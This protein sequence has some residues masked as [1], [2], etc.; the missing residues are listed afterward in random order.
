MKRYLIVAMVTILVLG[1]NIPLSAVATCQYE[2]NLNATIEISGPPLLEI[3]G[4]TGVSLVTQPS[5][6][7]LL[8]TFQPGTTITLRLHVFYLDGTPVDLNPLTASFAFYSDQAQSSLLTV[9]DAPVVPEPGAGPGYYLYNFTIPKDWSTGGVSV[10]AL[11]Q[12]LHDAGGNSNL[13]D[14]A[15]ANMTL[16][17]VA[18]KAAFNIASYAV[19]IIILILLLAA[20]LLLAARSRKKKN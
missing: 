18:A 7:R 13:D 10:V 3:S 6:I 9:K 11:A 8:Q 19:P 4:G 17:I 20:L 2:C 15:K 14:T 12:S 5:A 1:S 16:E